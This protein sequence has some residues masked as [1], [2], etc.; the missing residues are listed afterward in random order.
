MNAGVI[1]GIVGGVIGVAGGVFGTYMS[2][3]N[4]SG[5]QER[6]FMIRV[7]WVTWIVLALFLYGLFVLPKPYNWLLWAPYGIALPLGIRWCNRRQAQIRA[8][9]SKGAPGPE[10]R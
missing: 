10:T 6:T 1:G 9:E 4:T 7:A 8:E 3:R 2:I 5:P